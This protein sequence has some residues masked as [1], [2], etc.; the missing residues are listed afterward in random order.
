MAK[1][2]GNKKETKY[3]RYERLQKE[4]GY[5]K[6]HPWVPGVDEKSIKTHIERKRKAFEKLK[7]K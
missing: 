1:N 3:Q 2:D 4:R 7:A 6:I 5:V